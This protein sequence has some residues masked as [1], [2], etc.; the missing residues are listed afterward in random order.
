MALFLFIHVFS[1]VSPPGLR[2]LEKGGW[3]ASR[4]AGQEVGAVVLRAVLHS[5]ASRLGRVGYSTCRPWE[6]LEE[7]RLARWDGGLEWSSRSGLVPVQ[8]VSGVICTANSF[9]VAGPR[10]ERSG[11]LQLGWPAGGMLQY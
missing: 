10:E 1:L 7:C 3:E 5:E 8:S 9:A 11:G 2:A 6:T 4:L